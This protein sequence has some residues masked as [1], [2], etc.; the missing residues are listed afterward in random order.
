V[1]SR[2]TE[3]VRS[4]RGFGGGGGAKK[5]IREA[6]G[7][8]ATVRDVFGRAQGE[9]DFS[10]W[11]VCVSMT[12]WMYGSRGDSAR[13]CDC[14]SQS[15]DESES[16]RAVIPKAFGKCERKTTY[17]CGFGGG[18]RF[19]VGDRGDVYVANHGGVPSTSCST[20]LW[21]ST[22]SRLGGCPYD[23]DIELNS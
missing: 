3:Y 7:P 9:C 10:V 19:I 6:V 8:Y 12:K 18:M 14:S 17:T 23:E 21:R 2:R 16:D 15:Q 22:S 1:A 5:C 4:I 13:S 11:A 20:A